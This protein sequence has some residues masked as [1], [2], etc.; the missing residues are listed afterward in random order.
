[1]YVVRF[2]AENTLGRLWWEIYPE[3]SLIER[4]FMVH[5]P[6]ERPPARE[7]RDPREIRILDPACGSGHFLHYCFVLLEVIYREAYDL[8]ARTDHPAC[9]A[10][11]RLRADFPDRKEFEREIPRLI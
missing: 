2:L 5:R 3:T 9:A 4:E 11:Q 10:G 1:E 7:V 8:G 6:G